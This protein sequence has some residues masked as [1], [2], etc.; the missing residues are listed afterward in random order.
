MAD[1]IS[2]F[3]KYSYSEDDGIFDLSKSFYDFKYTAL[4]KDYSLSAIDE[5]NGGY[6]LKDEAGDFWNAGLY[7][8]KVSRRIEVNNASQFYGNGMKAVACHDAQIG[9][10]VAWYSPSSGRRGILSHGIIKNED[11]KQVIDINGEFSKSTLRG[12][13]TFSVVLYLL[14]PGNPGSKESFFANESGIRL[15]ELEQITIYIDG[16]A[17]MFPIVF[18][19]LGNAPLWQLATTFDNPETDDFS[20]TVLLQINTNNPESDCLDKRKKEV[21]NPAL[22]KEV[23]AGAMSLLTETV[24]GMDEKFSCLDNVEPGGETVANVIAYFQNTLGWSLDTP[25]TVSDSA[26]MY[27]EQNIKKL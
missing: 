13:I 10:A 27:L 9:I 1:I 3:P 23:V 4:D 19:D 2:L 12:K 25:Q 14:T 11:D 22:M 5:D 6:V 26:R 8:L 18:C 17:P 24:R 21:Y 7:N 20:S 16:D 15:G